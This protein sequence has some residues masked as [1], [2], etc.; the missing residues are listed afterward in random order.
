MVIGE[1][2]VI[3]IIIINNAWASLSPQFRRHIINNNIFLKKN[4]FACSIRIM[5]KIE[6]ILKNEILENVK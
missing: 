6:K 2:S 1:R 4:L 3:I 5:N